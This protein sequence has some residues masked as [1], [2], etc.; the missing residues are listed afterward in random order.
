MCLFCDFIFPGVANYGY[1]I[2]IADIIELIE[3]LVS[4]ANPKCILVAHDWGG[5]LAWS[6][7]QTRPD[8]VDRFIVLNAPHSSPWIKRIATT[9]KQFFASWY[10]FFFNFPYLPELNL[11]SGDFKLFDALFGKYSKSPEEIDVYK[12]YFSQAYGITAPLNYYRARLRGYG[13][14]P[15][16]VRPVQPPTLILWGRDDTA[17]IAELA[18]DSAKLCTDATVQYLDACSHWIMID[19]PKEVNA[20]IAQFLS[21]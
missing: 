19:K 1:D 8:L 12:H 7:A 9:W 18:E 15:I 16:T 14:I 20:A 17:L 13:Q 21:R 6:V 2:L 3:S 10:M 11:R 5:V 4:K